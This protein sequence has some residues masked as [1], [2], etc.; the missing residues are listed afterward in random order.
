MQ[1][2]T[3]SSLLQGMRDGAPEAWE[4]IVDIWT[5]LLR[6]YCQKKGFSA[7]S[8]DDI[9][10]NIMLRLYRGIQG[11]QR[12]GKGKRLRFWIMAITRNEVAE[13]C[14][15]NAHHGIAMGG[16]EHQAQ[17]ALLVALDDNDADEEWCGPAVVL[18]RTMQVIKNDFKPNV[19]QAFELFKCNQLTAREAA[20]RLNMTENA[21]RQASLRVC[22]RLKEEM[23]SWFAVQ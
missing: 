13:Y 3:H 7:T 5:P 4:R 17:V 19:W 8:A 23:D 6:N 16:S 1:E 11:F 20:E 22:Q 15:R 14:R 9:T 10:Q 2:T 18:S 21:V 12:D